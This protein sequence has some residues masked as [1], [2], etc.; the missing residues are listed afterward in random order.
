MMRLLSKLYT[1]CKDRLNNTVSFGLYTLTR[2]G[3]IP[4]VW[5]GIY[6][7]QYF[8]YEW[9]SKLDIGTFIDI[10]AHDGTVSTVINFISPKT[11]IYAF[12]P[13]P[14]KKSLIESKVKSDNLIVETAALSN[15]EGSQ[16]FFEYG[17]QTASSLLKPEMQNKKMWSVKTTIVKKYDV[18]VTTLDTYFK[19]RKLKTPIFIKMDT[20]GTEDL[21]IKGGR[22]LLKKASAVI[23]ETSF[24]KFYKNQCLFGD[25]YTE[26]T[27][28]GFA[29]KGN[30]KESNFYPSFKPL[31]AE[32]SLFVKGDI[33][34][35][36]FK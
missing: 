13:I 24:I 22:K 19:N 7:P 25:V 20:Q 11:D 28:L 35:S 18:S 2:T 12:E 4:L 26:M 23:I 27:Q 17:F 34:K 30:L 14:T 36:Y 29:Y 10:G 8:Q 5:Q 6:L 15:Y 16:E 32:N 3:K 31:V 21:I 1:F 33:S 9:M